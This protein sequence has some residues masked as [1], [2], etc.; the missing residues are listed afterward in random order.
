MVVK[1]KNIVDYQITLERRSESFVVSVR[2]EGLLYY[3][4]AY[5]SLGSARRS[6][7]NWC[8]KIPDIYEYN[9]ICKL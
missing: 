1:E 6:Y 3:V 8:N 4:H 2:K 7:N 9:M 5:N